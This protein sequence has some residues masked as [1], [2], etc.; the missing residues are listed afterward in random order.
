MR[1]RLPFP[2]RANNRVQAAFMSEIH[3]TAVIHHEATIGDDCVIGPY[4]I[5][6]AHVTLGQ[7]NRLHSHVVIDG[8]TEIGRDNVFF[9]FAAI[10]LQTQDLKWQGGTTWTRIGDRNTF[11]ENVTVHSATGDSEATQIGSDNHILAYCHIAHNVELGNHIIM[12]NNGTLAGHVIVEDYA[13][14]GGLAAV[15]QFCRLGRMSIIGGCS[16]IVSDVAPF[17]MVDGNPART[18]AVNKVGLERNGVTARAQ[19]A[20]RKAHR[21]YFRKGLTVDNAVQAIRAEVPYLPEVEHF[22]EFVAA[23]DRGITR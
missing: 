11:R 15:H 20:L 7:A 19:D 3:P 2:L 13:I 1:L 9:P 16:K 23:R 12:S 22:I 6:G 17:M 18:R 14:V 5:I 21:L 10:G 8:Y 4:C